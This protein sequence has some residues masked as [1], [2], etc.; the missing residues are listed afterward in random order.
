MVELFA[1]PIPPIPGPA[2]FWRRLLLETASEPAEVRGPEGLLLS[3][4]A[5]G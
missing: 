3:R 2:P 4:R 5:P 1:P